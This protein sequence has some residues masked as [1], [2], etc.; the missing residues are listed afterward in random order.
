VAE[1]SVPFPVFLDSIA[2]QLVKDL[3]SI[4]TDTLKPAILADI[5][6]VLERVMSVQQ[7]EVYS[8]QLAVMNY[9]QMMGRI[10]GLEQQLEQLSVK[11]AGYS[12]N[13]NTLAARVK[14][15]EDK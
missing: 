12:E 8:Y 14:K 1:Q 3:K 4:K 5:T 6:K 10:V 11:L 13:H 15:L 2:A 9:E 7:A